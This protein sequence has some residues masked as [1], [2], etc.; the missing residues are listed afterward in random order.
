MTTWKPTKRP[1]PTEDL[2]HVS[3][4]LGDRMGRDPRSRLPSRQ[5]YATY[6]DWCQ[7][8]GLSPLSHKALTMALADL[9]ISTARNHRERLYC[10]L[11]LV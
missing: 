4:F 3:D 1:R 8:L 10:G 2:T 6:L 5:V 9:G 7:S 11:Q